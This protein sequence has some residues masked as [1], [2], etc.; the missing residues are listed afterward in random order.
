MKELEE[1]DLKKKHQEPVDFR[2]CQDAQRGFFMAF[3]QMSCLGG[4]QS[5]AKGVLHHVRGQIAFIKQVAW[6]FFPFINRA[7]HVLEP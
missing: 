2:G 7:L 6:F 1:Q 5:K 3:H 4:D